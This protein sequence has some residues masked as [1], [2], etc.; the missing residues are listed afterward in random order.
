MSAKRTIDP[1]NLG[2]WELSVLSVLREGPKHPYEIQRLL[3]LRHKDEFLQLKKGSLYHA[4]RRLEAAGLIAEK[5]TL[6]E[7]QRPEKTSYEMTP[8][9]SAAFGNW[10]LKLVSEIQPE[11][12]SFAAAIS[13]LVYL[14]PQEAL[15]A[16]ENR[17]QKLQERIGELDEILVLVG[18]NIGRIFVIEREYA[19]AVA[20]AEARWVL[21]VIEAIRAKKLTWDIEAI[22]HELRQAAAT[23]RRPKKRRK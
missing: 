6:R 8:A 13:F 5:E 3:R 2:L 11:A 18:R 14:S 23:G 4:I 22:L 16:L 10:L 9:G 15:T 20:E 12:T 21:Q 17:V 19:R 1:D 7:G